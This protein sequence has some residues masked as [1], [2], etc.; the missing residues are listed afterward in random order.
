MALMP[1]TVRMANSS[2]SLRFYLLHVPSMPL[3]IIVVSFTRS[4]SWLM[5]G[6]TAIILHKKVSISSFLENVVHLEADNC[7]S[8]YAKEI[9]MIV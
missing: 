6:R 4:L 5:W 9:S 1:V 7:W 8:K 2:I 3:L